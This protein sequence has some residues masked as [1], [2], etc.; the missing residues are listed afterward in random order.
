MLN[1][2]PKLIQG[3]SNTEYRLELKLEVIILSEQLGIAENNI[4]IST[5]CAMAPFHGTAAAEK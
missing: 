1:A 3:P 4:N 5:T 2:Y